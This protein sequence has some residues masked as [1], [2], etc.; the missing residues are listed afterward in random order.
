MCTRSTM[1]KPWVPEECENNWGVI[2]ED[3]SSESLRAV[4][5]RSD[6]LWLRFE[7]C[8]QCSRR[9]KSAEG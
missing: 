9:S 2:P 7:T 8:A 3:P 4:H 5:A 1:G 6:R